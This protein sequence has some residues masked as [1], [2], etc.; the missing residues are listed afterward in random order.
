MPVSPKSYAYVPFVRVGHAA[1]SVAR[2]RIDGVAPESRSA[3]NGYARP[4]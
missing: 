2:N 4:A 1:G 3:M